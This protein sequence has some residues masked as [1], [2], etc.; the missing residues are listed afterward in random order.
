MILLKEINEFNNHKRICI[1]KDEKIYSSSTKQNL[2]SMTYDSEYFIEWYEGVLCVEVLLNLRH[3][4][5]YAML[6]MEYTR[7]SLDKLYVDVNCNTENILFES[8]VLPS[9]RKVQLGLPFEFLEGIDGGLMEYAGKRLPVGNLYIFGGGFDEIGSSIR[10]FEDVVKI[11]VMLF[12]G[13]KDCD[14][15]NYNIETDR[16]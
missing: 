11:M 16:M 2:Y 5:N 13:I 3:A 4:S 14:I 10:S 12:S 6:C 8:R 9:K 15:N 1:W 7:S